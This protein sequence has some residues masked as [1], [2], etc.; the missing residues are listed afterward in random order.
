VKFVESPIAGAFVV[1]PEP[2]ADDRGFFA[3]TFCR[4]EFAARGLNPDLVQ[5]SV[6]FNARRGTLRGM[7]YQREPHAEAKLVRC[8]MGAIQDVIV[9]LRP[10]SPTYRRWHGVELTALNRSALYIPEGIAHGFLTLEDASEVYYQMAH[11]FRPESAA[12]VRW[13]DR[14]FGIEWADEVRVISERDRTYP[15]FVP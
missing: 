1:E 12:G 11:F 14:A 3:R 5:C 15:D 10:G 7:H 13:D 2:V 8:T 6:S 9:D 4:D